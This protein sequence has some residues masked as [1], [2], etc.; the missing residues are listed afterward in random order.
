MMNTDRIKA[1]TDELVGL[2]KELTGLGGPEAQRAAALA[3]T[4]Y[5][6]GAHWV[7]V[8]FTCEDFV[9]GDDGGSGTGEPRARVAEDANDGET[10]P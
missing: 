2:V 9:P 1:K 5:Q 4:N 8:A 3:V 7:G 6:Q 10:D